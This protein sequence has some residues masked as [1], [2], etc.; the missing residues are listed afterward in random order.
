MLPPRMPSRRKATWDHGMGAPG[1]LLIANWIDRED[2]AL[3]L[4]HVPL[5]GWKGSTML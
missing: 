1:E 3:P 2:S 4:A 5:K